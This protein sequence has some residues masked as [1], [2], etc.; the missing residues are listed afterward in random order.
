[1]L[2]EVPKRKKAPFGGKKIS[3]RHN[4]LRPPV[5]SFT[6]LLQGMDLQTGEV[7]PSRWLTW[8]SCGTAQK[9]RHTAKDSMGSSTIGERHLSGSSPRQE[10]KRQSTE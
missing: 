1:M 3:P 6:A 7:N 8:S 4:K 2:R 5:Q 10:K 9:E